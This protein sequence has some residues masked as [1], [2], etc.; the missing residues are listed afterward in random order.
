MIATAN[1]SEMGDRNC[2]GRASTYALDHKR[3]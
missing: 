3:R 1:E 2:A